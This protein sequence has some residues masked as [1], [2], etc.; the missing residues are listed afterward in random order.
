MRN[1]A[2]TVQESLKRD[3]HGGDLYIFRG[4]SEAPGAR[5][6]HLAL[7]V[8]RRDIDLG[9]AMHFGESQRVQSVIHCVA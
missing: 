2:L 7:G 4:R 5:Q 8:G 1:L 9:G 3:P 6:V